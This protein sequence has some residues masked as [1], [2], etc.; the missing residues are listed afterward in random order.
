MLPSTINEKEL[1]AQEWMDSL[2]LHYGIDP[3]D[4]PEHFNSCGAAF[5]IY[6]NLDC[7]KGGLITARQNELRDGV[8]N[9]ASKAFTP[10]HMRDDQ[11]VS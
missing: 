10:M 9:L 7:K 3:P 2:F 6:H 11:N 8:A 4:L 1:G 5:S